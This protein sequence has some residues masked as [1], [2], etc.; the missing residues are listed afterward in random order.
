MRTRYWGMRAGRSDSRSL[1]YP[2][3]IFRGP[4]LT[5]VGTLT[6]ALDPALKPQARTPQAPCSSSHRNPL[7]KHLGTGQNLKFSSSAPRPPGHFW[8]PS[9]DGQA[10]RKTTAEW[11]K[12]RPKSQQ[13][14]GLGRGGT[15]LHLRQVPHP[16]GD[17]PG[18]GDEVAHGQGPFLRVVQIAGVA[19]ASTADI[20]GPC[21]AALSEEA[22]Q[23]AILGIL[24]NEQ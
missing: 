15:Y 4:C 10:G 18:K 8:L 19:A 11:L 21:L 23:G 1:L 5:P 3:Q 9:P 22:P 12:P 24:H 6:A 2:H 16:P 7:H 17:L 14:G 20:A 13:G